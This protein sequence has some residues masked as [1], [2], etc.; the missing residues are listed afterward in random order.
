MAR[1]W[2][3]LTTL[4]FCP[5]KELKRV[6]RSI[7]EIAPE[8]Q[9]YGSQRF[10]PWICAWILKIQSKCTKFSP[11]PTYIH[12][13]P[14]FET[15][16]HHHGTQRRR[17]HQAPWLPEHG[18]SWWDGSPGLPCRWHSLPSEW[19]HFETITS[20]YGEKFEG[21]G[22]VVRIPLFGWD[23]PFHRSLR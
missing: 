9:T 4:L 19:F 1:T 21:Q 10:A 16:S 14:F 8:R 22:E 13:H 6:V 3:I 23:R 18:K 20:S 5:R 11:K 17:L 15:I 2:N 7:C 12:I